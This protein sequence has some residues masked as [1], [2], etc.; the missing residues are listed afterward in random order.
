MS[1]NIVVNHDKDKNLW[2]FVPEGEIDIYTS[3][4][5]KKEVL[6]NF[7]NNKADILIDGKQLNYIDSTGLG[8]LISILKRLKENEYK[9]YL[10]NLRPN[11]R[12][13]FDIT[14]LDKLFIIR[15]E[16]SE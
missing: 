6:Y 3:S 5:L 13:I 16:D 12:K 1:L 4:K 10:S 7:E 11:I 9:I 8:A 15:G 2:V 14:E